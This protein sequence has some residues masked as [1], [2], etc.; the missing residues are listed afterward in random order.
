MTNARKLQVIAERYV[1]EKTDDREFEDVY[2]QMNDFALKGWL[3]QAWIDEAYAAI[4]RGLAVLFH[5]D[6]EKNTYMYLAGSQKA[7]DDFKEK[8]A[9]GEKIHLGGR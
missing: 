6:P 2:D 9:K 1:E 3:S 5:H 8:M 7:L 4:R